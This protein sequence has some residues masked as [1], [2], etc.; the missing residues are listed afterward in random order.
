MNDPDDDSHHD[1]RLD[2]QFVSALARGLE[3]LQCFGPDELDLSN[4]EI[5]ART[6]LPKS[7][8]TRLTYTLTHLGFM[9]QV[10][11]SG[12][13]RIGPAVLRLG[14]AFLANLEIRR[15]AWPLMQELAAFSGV[16][17]AL[18]QREG[19]EMIYVECCRGN[20]P[21]TLRLGVG[22]RIDLF[23][24]IMGRAWLAA[25]SE[26]ELEGLLVGLGDRAEEVAGH[27][28]RARDEI[29]A[30]GFCVTLGGWTVG[31]NS[32]AAPILAPDGRTVMGLNCGGPESVMTPD[33]IR[34]EVGP[35]LARLAA[36]LSA[37]PPPAMMR[38]CP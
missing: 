27:V 9:Q 13:Y 30:Q 17:V 10:E 32:A 23:R 3:I 14:Y 2:R 36:T 12:F 31:V 7:T 34:Q 24:S 19:G 5:A 21:V 28:A 4:Q 33:F 15:R 22:S 6:K 38:C 1:P 25:Q 16:S 29:A 20:A 26:A 8:V 18:G 35:R 11:D 37:L